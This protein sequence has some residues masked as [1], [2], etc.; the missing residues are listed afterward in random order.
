MRG[1]KRSG[2][3]EAQRARHARKGERDADAER[4]PGDP[5][6]IGRVEPLAEAGRIGGDPGSAA[7]SAPPA[8]R[9]APIA[10]EPRARSASP[11][12]PITRWP[13]KE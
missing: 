12:E 5:R 13:M 9:T 6:E 3:R 8:L 2:A 11:N 4:A 7:P 1:G 10:D